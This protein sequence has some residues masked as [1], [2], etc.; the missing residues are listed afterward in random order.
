MKAD[1]K[2]RD[3]RPSQL[4]ERVSRERDERL[5]QLAKGRIS[6]SCKSQFHRNGRVLFL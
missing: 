6:E 4:F 5:K 1:L 3:E 2:Q